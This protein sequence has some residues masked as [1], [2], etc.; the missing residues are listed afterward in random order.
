MKLLRA[1]RLFLKLTLILVGLLFGIAIAEIALRVAGYSFPL[2]YTPD[3]SRGYAL[4]PGSEG[5]F[6]LEGS[7]SYVRIN[8]QGLHDI[9]HTFA[10]PENT[11]RIAIIGD[12]YAE[13]MHAGLDHAF[14]AVLQAKLKECNAF[15]GKNVEVINFGVSGYGTA[16]EL[17]TLREQAWK[18]SSDIVILAVTT[19]NDVTDNS[20]LLK[21]TGDIPYFVFQNNRLT[22]DDS[23]KNSKSIIGS[24]STLNR[25]GRWLR[26][27]LR[28]VQAAIE[29]HRGLKATIASWR[30]RRSAPEPPVT[31]APDTSRPDLLSRSHEL[32]LDNLIYREPGDETWKDAWKVTEQLIV[33][34]RD[35]V[36]SHHAR[37]VVVTLSNGPQVLPG[38][39]ARQY[40]MQRFGVR[41][42]F[43][44]DNRIKALGARENF[45]VITLAPELQAFAEQNQTFLHGF[46][47]NI[48]NGHWNATGHR[49]AGELIAK[50][51][52]EGELFK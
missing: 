10:K 41:D 32:G 19:S 37:F 25:F 45:E 13:A 21:Q 48:G 23:F 20:R 11:I 28:V 22:L 46:G 51:M 40:F 1:R 33:A 7:H 18:Y 6:R 26:V 43:Y 44:P 4:L 3:A 15:G 12:S 27:H 39:E 17:I 14:W 49:V 38:R 16:Q 35:E 8:S 36:I 50:K 2:F 9:E 34:A 5:D 47:A 24:N 30:S 52:C 42:L 31:P 29:A